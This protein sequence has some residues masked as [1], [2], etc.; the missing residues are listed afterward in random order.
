M[1]VLLNL[2]EVLVFVIFV[3]IDFVRK[4]VIESGKSVVESFVV[5]VL[6]E[7]FDEDVFL[8]SFF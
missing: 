1:K 7:V 4:N 8:I 6:V 5:N 3:G 2:C